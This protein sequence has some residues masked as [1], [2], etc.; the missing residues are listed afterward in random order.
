MKLLTWNVQWFLGLDGV[1]DVARV[2]AHARSL[3]DFD[4]LCLQEVSVNLTGLKG[5]GGFDQAAAVAQLLPEYEVM[6]SPCVDYRSLPG[7]P[8]ERFGNLVATRLPAL[9]VES[10]P[11]PQTRD[12]LA[13][14][15]RRICTSVLVQAQ[16]GPLTIM[17]THLE[18]HSAAQRALQVQ[19]ILELH[20]ENCDL[21]GTRGGGQPTEGLYQ[22]RPRSTRAV[23]CGDFNFDAGSSEHQSLQRG[24]ASHSLRDVF[25]ALHGVVS[26]PATFGLYD[27]TYVKHPI[28]CDHVFA[29]RDIVGQARRIEVD[30]LTQYSDHQPIYVELEGV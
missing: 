29:T 19:R 22:H 25:T 7:H 28:A 11:L 26:R 15:V 23:L 3:C 10:H 6:F 18:Y 9:L 1:V 13:P 14:S 5:G 4:V 20:R 27:S 17:N 30:G 12:A 2:I 8:R 16:S 21:A 24:E